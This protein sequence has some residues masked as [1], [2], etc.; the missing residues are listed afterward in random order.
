METELDRIEEGELGWQ[1]VLQNFYGPF[2]QALE[3][4]D[5]NALVAEA[6][7]LSPEILNKEK[8]PKCGSAIVLKT[9]RFG[10]YLACVNYKATCDYVKSLKRDKVPDRP[11]DE[12]CHLCGSA[13]VIKTGRFG[14][15]LAC[16]AYP[17]CKGTRSIPLGLK[18]PKCLEGDLAERRTKRGKSFW[19]CVRY[20][21]CDF[22]TW[23]RPVPE[24]CPTCGWLGMERK[25]SK[26]KGESLTCLK[27]GH[28]MVVLDAEEAAAT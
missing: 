6:H 22:S 11:T 2:T 1:K 23:N 20:P 3:A 9:G 25:V 26:A 14:E 21:A 19:G 16:T 15:F 4:V 10:P 12:K 28:Q 18:C 13:M 8:C 27:C 7:G 17:K 5:I 24:T